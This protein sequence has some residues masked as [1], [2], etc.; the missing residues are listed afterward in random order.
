MLSFFIPQMLQ[1]NGMTPFTYNADGTVE[2]P[3]R[4]RRRAYKLPGISSLEG[5]WVFGY[6]AFVVNFSRRALTGGTERLF[7]HCLSHSQRPCLFRDGFCQCVHT[8]ITSQFR[9][10]AIFTVVDSQTLYQRNLTVFRWVSLITAV[11]NFTYKVSVVHYTQQ[12]KHWCS[13]CASLF[14]IQQIF[15][16]K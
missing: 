14:Y 16:I 12:I 4:R 13:N 9:I 5:C 7:C 6:V 3:S 15:S 8:D 2:T 11:Q 10:V 1:H